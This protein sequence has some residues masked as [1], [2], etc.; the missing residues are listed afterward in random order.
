MKRNQNKKIKGAQIFIALL[1]ALCLL[2]TLGMLIFGES[3]AGANEVLA[4]AP[5]LKNRD[6]SFNTEVLSDL[7]DYLGD[8]FFLRQEAITGWNAVNTRLLK[9]S[10]AQNVLPGRKGWLYYA[11]TL[12]DYTRSAPLSEKELYSAARILALAQEYAE[13]RDCRFVFTLCP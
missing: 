3:E 6:G 8:R 7:A 11:D 13:S 4:N 9:D 10:P 1:M 2:P 12:P 5:R